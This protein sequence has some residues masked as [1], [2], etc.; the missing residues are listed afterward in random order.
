MESL[1][2]ERFLEIPG[3]RLLLSLYS[4]VGHT[5]KDCTEFVKLE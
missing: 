4:D 3:H 5:S 2:L 1:G